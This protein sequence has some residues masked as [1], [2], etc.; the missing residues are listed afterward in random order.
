[1][2][3]PEAGG[4][5]EVSGKRIDRIEI[6]RSIGVTEFARGIAHIRAMLGLY[7]EFVE[8]TPVRVVALFTGHRSAGSSAW[9]E[10]R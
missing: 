7:A 1:M 5:F 10:Y 2:D 6:A 9:E 3:K 4:G 8:Q